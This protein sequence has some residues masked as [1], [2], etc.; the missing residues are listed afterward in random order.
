VLM[1]TRK[2]LNVLMRM[3]KLLADNFSTELLSS[4]NVNR[5]LPILL[6]KLF[7]KT[8]KGIH[9]ITVKLIVCNLKDANILPFTAA[10]VE[11]EEISD[12]DPEAR[13]HHKVSVFFGP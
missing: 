7:M 10:A 12:K 3:S 1:R 2:L 9:E 4:V 8:D 11:S 6:T 13:H 5:N